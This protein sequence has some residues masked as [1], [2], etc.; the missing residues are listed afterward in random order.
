MLCSHSAM[1]C[2]QVDWYGQVTGQVRELCC[3]CCRA[4]P[5]AVAPRR[6][7]DADLLTE[8]QRAPH[9]LVDLPAAPPPA[10]GASETEEEEEPLGPGPAAAP[11]QQYSPGDRV[12]F[13]VAIA[14]AA[15][16]GGSGGW[17]WVDAVVT[18]V[19]EGAA[20]YTVR[21]VGS[22]DVED[23]TAERLRPTPQPARA[24][25]ATRGRHGGAAGNK[26]GAHGR[27]RHSEDN[28]HPSSQ[29]HDWQCE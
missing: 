5:L 13:S 17:M 1:L 3:P 9:R 14:G 19:R 21:L 24:A 11:I 6:P 22:G 20:A 26:C 18:E 12:Q 28:H 29:E 23:A 25:G 4:R 27:T 10:D 15:G 2:Y 16:G 8:E 7:G